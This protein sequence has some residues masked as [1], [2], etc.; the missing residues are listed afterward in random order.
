MAS[1]RPLAVRPS[2]PRAQ[3]AVCDERIPVGRTP[4]LTLDGAVSFVKAE[5]QRS[6]ERVFNFLRGQNLENYP[7]ANLLA[8]LGATS[9][10]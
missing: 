5:L 7:L 9:L 2:Y 1:Y 4:A 6:C 8:E 10:C 3:I